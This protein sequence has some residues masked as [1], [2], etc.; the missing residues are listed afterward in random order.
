MSGFEGEISIP[1]LPLTE[2]GNPLFSFFQFSPPSVD[3]YI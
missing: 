2:L 3:L 1:I